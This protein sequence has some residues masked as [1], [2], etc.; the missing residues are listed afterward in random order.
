MKS[1]TSQISGLG[2]DHATLTSYPAFRVV[3]APV[4][5][6]SPASNPQRIITVCPYIML[7][8]LMTR[9]FIGPKSEEQLLHLTQDKAVQIDPRAVHTLE[10]SV[11]IGLAVLSSLDQGDVWKSFERFG[12]RRGRVACQNANG[13]FRGGR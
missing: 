7:D 3:M 4:E 12:S 6:L 9:N 11:Q 8:S 1:T 10:S 5:L 2:F 13:V